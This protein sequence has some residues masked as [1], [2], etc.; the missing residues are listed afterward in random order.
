V[1]W[2]FFFP[3]CLSVKSRDQY[4]S[5]PVHSIASHRTFPTFPGY[6]QVWLCGSLHQPIPRWVGVILYTT[7][8]K[9]GAGHKD[10]GEDMAMPLYRCTA[11][12]HGYGTETTPHE[13]TSATH[14]RNAR[15]HTRAETGE[16]AN[17]R[18][19]HASEA[20]D[21]RKGNFPPAFPAA[22]SLPCRGT[23]SLLCSKARGEKEAYSDFTLGLPAAGS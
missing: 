12:P 3:L 9:R 21:Q 19:L 8:S 11:L 16:G 14:A 1:N 15:T 18:T 4:S 17:E 23:G 10:R 2:N 22:P 20:T 13:R 5:L 7:L 6:H